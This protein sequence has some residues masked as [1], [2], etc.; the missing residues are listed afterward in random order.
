MSVP[1]GL[2]ARSSVEL[3]FMWPCDRAAHVL[4]ADSC[5]SDRGLVTCAY[6]FVRRHLPLAWFWLG[7]L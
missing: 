2:W 4:L 1:V 5:N 7:M 6:S 3:C